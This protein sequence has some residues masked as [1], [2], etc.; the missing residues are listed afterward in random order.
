MMAEA[1]ARPL[2]RLLDLGTGGI[3]Q[4]GRLVARLLEQA[5]AA[6]LGLAELL[7]RVA[8]GVGEQVARL[9]AGCVED[10][11]P[12]ALALEAVALDL[13]LTALEL[14]LLAAHLFLDAADLRGGCALRVTLDLVGELGGGTDQVQRVHAHGVP[15]RLDAP[16]GAGGLEDAQLR[17][18]LQDMAAELVEGLGN[19]VAL[20]PLTGEREVFE[21]RQRCQRAC[22]PCACWFFSG[23]PR[24]SPASLA[25]PVAAV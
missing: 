11:G 16:G 25:D 23:H 12:L 18:Q 9:G 5:G 4:L 13:A 10:V 6:C 21:P 3:R 14:G 19:A 8:V 22:G 7:R 17:L 15:G 24:V 1:C 20:E 2:E